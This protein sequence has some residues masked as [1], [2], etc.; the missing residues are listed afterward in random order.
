MNEAG[1]PDQLI[2]NISYYLHKLRLHE[3]R[4]NQS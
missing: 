1:H 2:K 3:L 4:K